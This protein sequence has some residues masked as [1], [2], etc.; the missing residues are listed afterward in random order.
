MGW[1]ARARVAHFLRQ[2]R[3]RMEWHYAAVVMPAAIL[4]QLGRL[5]LA[6]LLAPVR[7]VGLVIRRG[8]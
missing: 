7:L 8:T 3:R 4:W 6:L 1:A 5:A 2:R